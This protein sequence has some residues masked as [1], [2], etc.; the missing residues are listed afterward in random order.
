MLREDNTIAKSLVTLTMYNWQ[1]LDLNE[2]LAYPTTSYI[3]NSLKCI[4][5]NE[6]FVTVHNHLI[7]TNT[8]SSQAYIKMRL[9]NNIENDIMIL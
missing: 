9:I 5:N 1:S 4:D 3:W 6:E 8:G 2:R 7:I